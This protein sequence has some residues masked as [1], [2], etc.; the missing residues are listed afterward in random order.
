MQKITDNLDTLFNPHSRVKGLYLTGE[1]GNSKSYS[2]FKYLNEKNITYK[3]LTARVTDLSLYLTLHEHS[4]GVFVF[5]DVNFT[6]GLA[7]DL[8]KGA[9]GDKG[10]VCWVTTSNRLPAEV[11]D[12]FE[13]KGKIIIITNEG[14]KDTKKFYPLLSRTFIC[15]Q[16]LT[17]AQY[18][19]LAWRI[20][21]EN[22]VDFDK[23]KP[24][25]SVFLQHYDLRTIN[26][27]IDYIKTE[28][29]SLLDDLFK[30]DEEL[31][32]IDTLVYNG[33]SKKVIRVMWCEYFG[34]SKRTYYRKLK[35]YNQKCN[36]NKKELM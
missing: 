17:F 28:K 25:L 24:Y 23:L 13:F 31:Q 34:L 7:I 4:E 3:L 26:K 18:F 27:A 30:Y 14:I 20:C 29:A 22:K 21:N 36:K 32:Y 12:H 19:A 8:L 11:P 2:I 16:N 9:L 15:E 1:A 35:L 6:N 10:V 5:D 33:Y